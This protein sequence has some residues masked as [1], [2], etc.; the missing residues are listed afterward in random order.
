[1]PHVVRIGPGSVI[2]TLLFIP[3][4][5]LLMF[6]IPVLIVIILFIAAVVGAS[7]ILVSKGKKGSKRKDKKMY[8]GRVI[9]AEYK[10]K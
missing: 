6:F 3:L 10:I 2:A 1:M 8:E 7:S 9:D 4:F 5:I